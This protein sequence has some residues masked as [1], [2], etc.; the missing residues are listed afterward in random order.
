[1]FVR[2]LLIAIGVL[3]APLGAAAQP[4]PNVVTQ[5]ATIV[6]QSI[7]NATAP[8]SAGTSEV[9]HTMV[10]LAMYDAVIAVEGGYE[11]YAA[12]IEASPGADVRAAAATAA[13]LTARARIAASQVPF[14]D[15]QYASYLLT[16]ADGPAKASGIDVG[17]QASAAILTLRANDGFNNIVL[18]ECS[19]APP[20]AGEFE[21]DSGCPATSTAPQPVDVKVGF[22]KPYTLSSP[23]QYRPDGPNPMSS[24]AYAEEFAETRD[25]GR[26]NSTI[27]TSEQTDVAYFW[28]ENPYVHWNR[29]LVNLAVAQ[30]LNEREAARFF[31]MVHTAASD[32]IIAG[33]EAKYVYAAW[34][35]RTAIPRADTDD[36]PETDAD[37]SWRPLIT[38][39][40]PEYPSGHGF[41]SSA[42]LE[43]VGAFFG[44]NK[45]LWTIATSKAAVPALVRTE[46][47]YEHL[48]AL[49]REIANARVWGGLHWRHSVNHG[50]QIGRR[51]AAHVSR[52]YFRPVE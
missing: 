6:Q 48:N 46:R 41:W 18:Y 11:P 44:S 35:P 14:L 29:N 20:P 47:T 3:A 52:N 19:S 1:M 28:S 9:L 31:A 36:N 7:H 33:F 15:Q 5:W 32:A 51:V 50:A 13:Y 34:R 16:I 25:F 42:V 43:S 8:R 39:N 49:L 24:S 38:V 26:I 17:A 12:R 45:V 21:P 22:I 10:M 40:H 27:R 30:G 2:S 23:N 4:A 37:P